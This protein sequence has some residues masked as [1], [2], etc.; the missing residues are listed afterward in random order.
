M[1]ADDEAERVQRAATESEQTQRA[2]VEGMQHLE[3]AAV[4]KRK[5]RE[6]KNKEAEDARAAATGDGGAAGLGADAPPVAPGE[7]SSETEASGRKQD[8]PGPKSVAPSESDD[9]DPPEEKEEP[10]EGAAGEAATPSLGPDLPAA[11]AAGGAPLG[12]ALPV[13]EETHPQEVRWVGPPGDFAKAP[14]P[15]HPMM[16]TWHQPS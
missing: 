9:S 6:A 11:D 2:L 8:P 10:A 14:H 7:S 4:A 16:P 15:G 1:E 5:A 3:A 13:P 12:E